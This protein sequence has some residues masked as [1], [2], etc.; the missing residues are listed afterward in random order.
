MN[1]ILYGI[2]EETVRPLAERY[3]LRLCHSFEELLHGDRLLLQAPLDTCRQQLAFF[4]R[5][6]DFEERIDAVVAV[7]AEAAGAVRYCS[8][9]GKFFTVG[10]DPE[11]L[12]YELERILK[13]QAGR[14]C[15]H[16]YD[17]IR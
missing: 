14:L 17:E 13:T 9:P 3:G 1:I 10:G 15:A 12:Q 5:M 16:G 4:E 7:S 6:T 8:Q 2:A 11:H